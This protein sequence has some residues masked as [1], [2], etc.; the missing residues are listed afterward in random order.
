MIPTNGDTRSLAKWVVDN[1]QFDQ[2]ILEFGTDAKPNWIHVSCD[3]ENRRQ[4]LRATKQQGRT[5]Y[6]QLTSL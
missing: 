2:V 6:T 5:V 3:P 4:I 1:C